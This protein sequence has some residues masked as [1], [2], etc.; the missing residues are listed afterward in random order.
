MMEAIEALLDRP[1]VF[2]LGWTLLHFIWQGTL[3]AVL[4]AGVNVLLRRHSARLRYAVACSAMLL[5]VILPV[6]TAFL[7]YPSS[8]SPRVDESIP[9]RAGQMEFAPSSETSWDSVLRTAGGLLPPP[10]GTTGIDERFE[11]FLPW[12]VAL[13]MTGIFVLSLRF[14][15][16]WLYLQYVRK[17]KTAPV[18]GIWNDTFANLSRQLRIRR[19]VR[20]LE[21]AWVKA[22]VAI[23]WLKPVVLV[24]VGLLTGL[25]PQQVEVLL[26]HELAHIRRYDY[27][28]NLLQTIAE[29][30]LFY[31][32]ATWWVSHR[33]RVEREYYCDDLTVA[34]CA[35]RR[36]YAHALTALEERRCSSPRL[37]LAASGHPLLMRIY[38]L[39]GNSSSHTITPGRRLADMA[40]LSSL[41]ILVLSALSFGLFSISPVSANQEITV[42]LPGGATME[43]VWIEP[44]IFTM[45]SAPETDPYSKLNERPQH[46]VEITQG[47]Y[48]GK[49]EITQRQWESAMGTRPWAVLGQEDP[50]LPAVYISWDMIQDFIDVLNSSLNEEVY[51]MPTEAEWEYAGRAGTATRWSFGENES[52][53]HLYAWYGDPDRSIGPRPVG[54]LLANP[55]GLY[56]MHGNVYEWVND[57]HGIDYYHDCSELPIPIKDPQGAETGNAKLWRGGCYVN[58][59]QDTR[60]AQ[61][62]GTSP[63]AQ[64]SAVGTRLV[65]QILNQPPDTSDA[66][67]SKTEIWPPNNKMID[68]TVEGVSD[69]D[70][71]DVTITITAITDD[72][73]SDPDDIGGTGTSTAQV[74]AT[75]DGN[76]D[77]RVYTIS[78]VASDG[79]GG[80]AEGSVQVTVPHDQGKKK[81]KGR[82]KLVETGTASWGAIKE[83]AK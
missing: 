36:M 45:G 10:K 5:L 47:F 70:G 22:P 71:D 18:Q 54:Q 59:A 78:F 29:T 56:D 3:V 67:P 15:G 60:S 65:M 25:T 44:G 14:A 48:L 41:L 69:P 74:R 77:G 63:W 12:L 46:E 80:E 27:L 11:S 50:N 4:L 32:P 64:N 73:G 82:G 19:S 8:S 24:P 51:R 72:E 23:G 76:G 20:L 31:H 35:D 68:I 81:K 49:F 43:F 53:L 75:R 79:K 61:R 34:L 62:S 52:E 30:L 28:V 66:T 83:L 17:W 33:I 55:W 38:R 2:A 1:E 26:I 21:S 39:A 37:A 13:W 58:S 42:T 40:S 16:S 7:V 9:Y 57:W 6:A